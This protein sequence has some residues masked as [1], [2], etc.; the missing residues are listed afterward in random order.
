MRSRLYSYDIMY[1]QN[2]HAYAHT[3][4][5]IDTDKANTNGYEEAQ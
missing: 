2:M 1:E 4:I 3:Y 5:V